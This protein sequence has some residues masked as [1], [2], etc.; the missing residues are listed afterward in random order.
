MAQTG[1]Q[2]SPEVG[3]KGHFSIGSGGTK[4]ET[5]LSPKLTRKD[6]SSRSIKRSVSP[7]QQSSSNYRHVQN[8]E[9]RY[10]SNCFCSAALI[11]VI[12]YVNTHL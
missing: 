3:I 6:R 11:I 9:N 10:V 5:R 1:T 4:E 7:I 8:K 2:T 12:L